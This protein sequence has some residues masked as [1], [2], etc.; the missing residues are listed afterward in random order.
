[1][2]RRILKL[3]KRHLKEIALGVITLG[4]FTLGA[5]FLW[6]STLTIPDL[7]SFQERKVSQ[8]TKIYDRTGEILLYDLNRGIKRSVIPDSEISRNIKNAAVA[9]EDSEFYEH[10]GIKLTSILRAILANIGAGS[11]SQGGS[12]IT[13]QVV[14]NSLLTRDKKISR[15]LK[16]WVLALK[17]ERVLSKTEILDLY[18]N[19]APYGGT[20]YGIEE[21]SQSFFGKKAADLSITEAAYLA[22]LPNAPSYYSPYGNN[23]QRL[24]D[25]KNLVLAKMLEKNFINQEEYRQATAEKVTWKPQENLG[26][27]APHFVMF[28]RQYLEDT[29]GQAMIEQGGLKVI[30]TLDYGLQE[31]AEALAK[32]YAS[33]NKKNF[34]A[35][36]LSLVALDPKT[37]Q[38]LVMLGS[39]DYFDKEIDGNFNVALAHRQPGSSFKP[40]VYAEAFNKGYTPDTMVFDIP[41]EFDTKCNPDGTP[42][43]AGNENKCYMPVN[44]DNKY[45]G[46]I[47]FRNALAQSRNIPAIQ[48]L[49]LAGLKDSLR[50]AKDMG[51]NSLT[52]VGQYGLTLVLG[53]G[54]VSLLDMSDAYATFAT[55]GFRNP[56]QGILRIGDKTGAVL[57]EYQPHPIQVLPEQTALT[58]ND[59]LS[60]NVARAPEFTE[61]SALY[62]ESRPVAVKTGT[63]NDYRDA[64]ILG[65]TPN[66]VVGAWAGNNNN[67]PMEKKIAGF[68]VAPFWNAFIREALK[69]FPVETFK[70][71]AMVDDKTEL[72]PVL[73]GFWQGGQAY[74]VNKLSGERATE[75]TPQELREERVVKQVHSILY[76]VDKDNP[77]GPPPIN[78]S[79]DPQF[80]LWEYA[81]RKWVVENGI[82]EETPAVI[83]IMEDSMHRPEFAPQISITN[84][85][86]NTMY[87]KNQNIVI[88][89]N[90]SGRFPLSKIDYFINGSFVGSV[91][92]YPWSFAFVPQNIDNLTTDNE[93]RVVAY[94]NVLN[95][96]ETKI[97]FRVSLNEGQ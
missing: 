53:G 42:I 63:T 17:L 30:T 69:Q 46:P 52:N 48:V 20:I 45:L 57:E 3:R 74:F 81:V 36:N 90:A 96:S 35:E 2:R 92:R 55:G 85:I 27:K 87:S 91:N 83:P 80:K 6:V 13:Q 40:I 24:E 41:I 89:L 70:K 38:I 66:L 88:A 49:Y 1:M 95:K 54:E 73:A 44:F 78:P 58:I 43:I 82:I 56:Y 50:L 65:Y 26:I 33:E 79:D 10:R 34:N 22:S 23:K 5:L 14:K 19:E 94:D 60:D 29:Y 64:W 31:K 21:A 8:S 4:I 47:S 97:T 71:P 67:S 84:P 12:T 86:P 51:I 16:E 18:L 37:G 72:K 59:I 75:F 77:N 9:I 68:I 32:Q 62:I 25:R 7:S 28:I 76:W 15:K 93:I 11:F 61:R 39:R